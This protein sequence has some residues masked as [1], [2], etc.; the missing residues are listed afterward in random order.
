MIWA[1]IVSRNATCIKPQ[2]HS[3]MFRWSRVEARQGD[4]EILGFPGELLKDNREA[5]RQ[6][7]RRPRLFA[8]IAR[9]EEQLRRQ[10]AGLG[11]S[12]AMQ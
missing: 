3:R 9:Q 11:P 8:S 4:L 10:Q 6:V 5:E 12:I 1:P 2:A 7:F